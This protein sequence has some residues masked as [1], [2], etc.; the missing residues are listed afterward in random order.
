ML[1]KLYIG[2]LIAAPVLLSAAPT[3]A[4]EVDRHVLLISI[5]GMHALDYE[6]CK[7]AGTCPNLKELGEHGVHYLRTTSSRPSDSFP[8][9]MSIVT[10]G[11]PKTLGVYYDVAYDRVLAPP[12]VTTNYG[13]AGGTCTPGVANGTRTEYEEGIDFDYTLMNGGNSTAYTITSDGKSTSPVIDGGYLA[14]NPQMLPRDPFA[15][16]APV[17]PWNFVR[18][19]TI[20]GVIH[21]A[22]GYTAWA[23][24]H[25]V[26]ASVSGP[27]GTATPSNVDD[28]YAPE[29]N[30]NVVPMPGIIT[31]AGF[32]CGTVSTA[33]PVA[34]TNPPYVGSVTGDWTGNWDYVTCNDQL[35]VNAVLNWINGRTHLSGKSAPVP[36]IFG[37]NFQSVSVGQKLIWKGIKGGYQDAQGT[38][39]E[40]M[41]GQIEYVDAAIGQM[42]DALRHA[43]LLDSTTIIITAKHGQSPIDTNRFVEPGSSPATVLD[44][45]IP[46]SESVNNPTGIGPTEDDISLLWLNHSSDTQAAVD[47]LEQAQLSGAANLGLGQIFYGDSLAQLF[48]K[49]GIPVAN[50]GTGGDPRTPDIVVAPN[51][52][53]VYT[54]SSKKQAEHGGF[55]WDDTNVMLLVSNRSLEP[56]TVRS[57]VE[58]SQ[59]APT[60]LQ[61]LGLDP[62]DLSAVR[63]EG[64]PV[65]PGL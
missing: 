18:A 24:K 32:D 3:L 7:A 49:P 34:T 43:H 65:L 55:A 51:V 58:T 57:F 45:Y 20:F 31:A 47:A 48:G 22:G 23:D 21:Q 30:S 61:I 25:G 11:S 62:K 54:G 27:T 50:G 29:I 19:N 38:P 9:L 42:V 4:N 2:A 60:V 5:D 36:T 6:N 15:Q 63:A 10:G 16:C 56:R 44:N 26:Y 13:V 14:I 35:K 39:T 12:T 64:T 33:K 59:I 41:K 8:G 28:Y 1:K 52:G 53:I 40:P 46:Y 37:M 17:Y